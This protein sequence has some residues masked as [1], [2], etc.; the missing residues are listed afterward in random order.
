MMTNA[1]EEGYDSPPVEHAQLLLRALHTYLPYSL[2]LYRRIQFS[3]ARPNPPFAQIFDS[4]SLLHPKSSTESS[5]ANWLSVVSRQT[6]A[7]RQIPWLAAHIDLSAT[8]ETQVWAFAS[9]ELPEY[10]TEET[11]AQVLDTR[12]SL[13]KKLFEKIYDKDVP[14]IPGN[15]AETYLKFPKLQRGQQTF[16]ASRILMG[17]LHSDI[18]NLLP[19]EASVRL[20]QGPIKYLFTPE[21]YAQPSHEPANVESTVR[22]PTNYRFRPL[23]TEHIQIV[24]D[25]T[26]VPRTVKTMK[27]LFSV[28]LFY[29]DET[30]PIGWGFLGKD[31]SLTSL[32]TE[33]QHRGKGLAALISKELFQH[34]HE[35]FRTPK[36]DRAEAVFDPNVEWAHADVDES[37]VGSRRVMEKMGGDQQ[38]GVS[39]IEVE[40]EVLMGKNGVW[41]SLEK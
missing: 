38:W 6:Q 37:N 17:A 26:R 1:A 31:A 36:D 12:T 4:Y 21:C 24:L 40:L 35:Y 27:S 29:N 3:L 14:H 2:P 19:K 10:R 39:W 25:R 15:A 13:L 8:G 32:H 7:S 33:P 9:W 34:Q 28:G 11:T 30:N 16:S 23:Q 20:D 5:A 41:R 22:M 18:R